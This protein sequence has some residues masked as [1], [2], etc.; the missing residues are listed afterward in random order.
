MAKFA[1]PL[2]NQLL[3]ALPADALARMQ[4]KLTSVSLFL[5]QILYRPMEQI[6]AVFFVEEG[7]VSLVAELEDELPGEV[8]LV[9]LEGMVGTPLV[10]GV[11]TAFIE[12][13]VQTPGSALRMPASVFRQELE[14]NLPLR[15]LLQRYSEALHAQVSQTAAC[16]GRHTLEQRLARWLL[17]A[18]DRL[19]GDTL[20][21][22]QEF[23][24]MMLGVHRPSVTVAAGVLQKAGL[25]SYTNGAIKV[26]DR[27]LLEAASCGCYATVQRRFAQLLDP[28]AESAPR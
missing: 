6:E 1:S 28:N 3:A 5:R 2:R 7:F 12:S 8:G 4:P 18:L 11:D 9:G 20:P 25:I 26:L 15:S 14:E 24:A 23:L 27:H 21:L 17:M 10:S 19:D 16:N 13:M 22:T